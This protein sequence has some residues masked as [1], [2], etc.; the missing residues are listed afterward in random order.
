MD[1]SESLK[2]D[3]TDLVLLFEVIIETSVPMISS[4]KAQDSV[5]KDGE[6]VDTP[7]SI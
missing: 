1:L 5:V 3:L 6:N 7:V 4:Y 2:I